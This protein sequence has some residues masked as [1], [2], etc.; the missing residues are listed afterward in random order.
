VVNEV[1]RSGS[2][3]QGEE[4]VAGKVLQGPNRTEPID[5]A[6]DAWVAESNPTSTC[7]VSPVVRSVTDNSANP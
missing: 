4:L 5:I 6:T 7:V 3:E 1:P 2:A